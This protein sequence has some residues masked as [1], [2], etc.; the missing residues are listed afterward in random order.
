MVYLIT[1]EK[2]KTNEEKS[3][4]NLLKVGA[5]SMSLLGTPQVNAQINKPKIEQTIQQN[6]IVNIN[7]LSKMLVG[8]KS[9]AGSIPL[10]SYINKIWNG[11]WDKV[12]IIRA[13]GENYTSALSKVNHITDI[14]V[15]TIE[16]SN[17]THLY[18]KLPNGNI[19]VILL[20]PIK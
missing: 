14:K 3:I 18:R 17:S 4:S 1:F 20:I 10:D 11:K 7:K 16:S 12:K 19:E 8:Y 6:E 9:S 5:L 2:Y 13:I 15:R